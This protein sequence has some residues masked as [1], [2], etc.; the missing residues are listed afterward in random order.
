MQILETYLRFWYIR[1]LN[2]VNLFKVLKT[3]NV[4]FA[5][6]WGNACASN[7]LSPLLIKFISHVYMCQTIGYIRGQ[8]MTMCIFVRVK[9]FNILRF[10]ISVR[11]IFYS[12]KSFSSATC[13][14][15]ARQT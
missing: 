14:P 10:T 4:C 12:R 3:Y 8:L 2:I 13:H 7:L 5:V 9:R 1:F 15:G 11:G 6:N